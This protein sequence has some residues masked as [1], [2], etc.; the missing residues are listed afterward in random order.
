M[1]RSVKYLLLAV[2]V[3]IYSASSKAVFSH[4]S[5]QC[6]HIVLNDTTFDLRLMSRE[7]EG[8]DW[9]I[10]QSSSTNQ[11][12]FNPCAPVSIEGCH[13]STMCM[14]NGKNPPLSF[15][16]TTGVI[17]RE[18]ERG[19]YDL[20]AK[21]IGGDNCKGV[22]R[23]TTVHFKCSHPDVKKPRTFMTYVE[24]LAETECGVFMTVVS[25]FTCSVAEFCGAMPSEE[26]C[27]D[28]EGLCSWSSG[29]CVSPYAPKVGAWGSVY[30]Y[31]SHLLPNY[32]GILFVVVSVLAVCL[33]FSVATYC[34]L[35]RRKAIERARKQQ[36]RNMEA[37][38]NMYYMTPYSHNYDPQMV[39]LLP[40]VILRT[41]Q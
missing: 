13:N 32:L 18:G 38:E 41:E 23:S 39:Q 22:P 36:A 1:S 37:L 10:F 4:G 25:P 21:Y 15:G 6:S 30:I 16:S 20:S 3:F 40:V 35:K 14:K 33:V 11:Y 2:L 26:M 12:H 31:I 28:T 7:L 24:A 34:L 5:A 29:A 19:R 8:H 9:K 27:M 17:W